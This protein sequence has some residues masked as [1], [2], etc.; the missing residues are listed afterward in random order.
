MTA[1]LPLSSSWLDWGL[2][3]AYEYCN[4]LE[5]KYNLNVSYPNSSGY[6]PW[7]NAKSVFLARMKEEIQNGI[8]LSDVEISE[9]LLAVVQQNIEVNDLL[10]AYDILSYLIQSPKSNQNSDVVSAYNDFIE[11]YGNNHEF[12]EDMITRSYSIFRN[13]DNL[14][15]FKDSNGDVVIDPIFY[16]VTQFYDG[17]AFAQTFPDKAPCFINSKGKIVI[18]FNQEDFSY[19]NSYNGENY[20]PTVLA[21]FNEGVCMISTVGGITYIDKTG[22]INTDFL[23]KIKRNN[24]EVTGR[25]F[26][27]GLICAK[28]NN[29]GY[30]GYLDKNGDWAI[31]PRYSYAYDFM[32]DGFA[33]V[34]YNVYD[35]G[36]AIIDVDGNSTEPFIFEDYSI[37]DGV[38]I[39]ENYS[40]ATILNLKTGDVLYYPI[41]YLKINPADW[42]ISYD[43]IDYY[44]LFINEGFFVDCTR[45]MTNAYSSDSTVKTNISVV[46]ADGIV[47]T[48]FDEDEE[49]RSIM[50]FENGKMRVGLVSGESYSVDYFGEVFTE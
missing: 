2:S 39:L 6:N 22:K 36:L 31:S 48:S 21:H 38:A 19:Y 46:N 35:D 3:T 20:V 13:W 32:Q 40:L 8:S 16:S 28:D 37:N 14:Y 17:L 43:V 18:S 12:Q 4:N 1:S 27:N 30:Y 33:F 9:Y 24:I 34:S 45:Y 50:P 47:I 49:I 23:N 5:E 15:G 42:K 25:I 11:K 44:K 7:K 26:S 41:N 29:T 10:E